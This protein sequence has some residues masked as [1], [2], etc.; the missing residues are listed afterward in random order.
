MFCQQVDPLPRTLELERRPALLGM[1]QPL[2]PLPIGALE[3]VGK[4]MFKIKLYTWQQKDPIAFIDVVIHTRVRRSLLSKVGWDSVEL[5]D[6]DTQTETLSPSAMLRS[7]IAYKLPV[8]RDTPYSLICSG[9]PCYSSE[10][11]LE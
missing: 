2:A 6:A 5:T 3:F 7:S 11:A 4:C 9:K 10:Y 1:E 8:H